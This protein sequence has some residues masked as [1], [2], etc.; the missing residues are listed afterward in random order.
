MNAVRRRAW[1]GGT[2]ALAA[3]LGLG[4][5]MNG[6]GKSGSAPGQSGGSSGMAPAASTTKTITGAGATFPYPIY[7]KWN[8]AYY[9]QTGV[10]MNYQAIGSGGGIAQI[11]A[12]TV[13]FGASDAPL[14]PEKLDE[15]GLL[16][17]P[18]V[19]GGVVLVVNLPG[20]TPNQMRLTPALLAD[21][22]LQKVT[23]WNDPAV[24]KVNPDMDLP[25]L[26]IQVVHRSDGS[27]TTWIF[28]NY[29]SKVSSDWKSQVGNSTSVG[30]PCGVGGKGNPGVAAL[31]QQTKGAIG[32]VEYAYCLENKMTSTKLANSTGA[33][34]APTAE[35]FQAAAANADWADAPGFY[36]VLTNEPGAK[37]WPIAGATFILVYKQ[38]EK[39]ETCREV[40]RFFDWAY[41]HGDAMAEALYYI[42]MPDSVVKLVEQ[43]WASDIK[44]PDGQPVWTD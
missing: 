28:T 19:M 1:L 41:T 15:V 24:K 33:F 8:D 34:V 7:S 16:Q 4:I 40:L 35:A 2:L 17:F 32:Y 29:L 31:V 11:T 21:I 5:V 18:T 30:W 9:K 22:Y 36:M 44:G 43:K 27:G 26:D 23:K 25:D 10:K 12:K 42:P 37:S 13:N 6:C 38:Q 14:T 39:P 20:V 3:L